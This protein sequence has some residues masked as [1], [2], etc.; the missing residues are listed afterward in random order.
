MSFFARMQNPLTAARS[1]VHKADTPPRRAVISQDEA[2]DEAHRRTRQDDMNRRAAGTAGMTNGE[3][4]DRFAQHM[5]DIMAE[6]KAEK[7]N[8]AKNPAL[9]TTSTGPR[10]DGQGQST[11]RNPAANADA[12][13]RRS[14]GNTPQPT[15]KAH[16]NPLEG[17][18]KV[19]KPTHAPELPRR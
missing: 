1:A 11:T 19:I 16:G 8:A 3:Y 14:D 6:V 18:V 12:G 7:V 5:R 9:N 4:N 2:F 10:D 15:K 17:Q 13:G